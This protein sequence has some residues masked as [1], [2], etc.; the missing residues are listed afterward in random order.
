M[1]ETPKRYWM[2]LVERDSPEQVNG[3]PD[4]VTSRRS[5]LKAAGFSF[6][7]AVAVG[8]QPHAGVDGADRMWPTRRVSFPAGRCSMRRHAAAA[9]PAAVSSSRPAMD[10]PSRLK[11]IPITRCR[12]A[13][14]ARW[15][16]RRCSGCTTASGSRAPMRRG[17]TQHVDRRRQGDRRG[18]QPPQTGRRR[19]P[20]P[21]VDDYEPD[22]GGADRRVRRRVQERAPRHLRSDFGVGD[23][24]RARAH[25]RR[26]AA[27][28]LPLRSRRRHRQRRCRLS[29]HLDLTRGVHARLHQPAASGRRQ[30]SD[31]R[32]TCRSSRGC[33]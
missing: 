6:A 31:V 20:D 17:Q 13:R 22:H 1:S 5:F 24:R 32:T 28:A 21:D 30:P 33:R 19:R 11:G 26:P 8:L 12:A 18:A 3:D 14:P 29:R 4:F 15:D 9:S 23:P 16:R 10:V 25:P 27:P 7:G 2:S